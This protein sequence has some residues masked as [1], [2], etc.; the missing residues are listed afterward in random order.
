MG[1][2]RR[3]QGHIDTNIFI[4]VRE[5]DRVP[6]ALIELFDL[7]G[8]DRQFELATSEIA[9]PELIAKPLAESRHDLVEAYD[10]WMVASTWLDVAPVTRSVL[11]DAGILRSRYPAVKLPD[12]IHLSTAVATACSLFLTADTGIKGRYEFPPSRHSRASGGRKVEIIRPEDGALQALLA[13]DER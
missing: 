11:W 10:D 9:L 12:A 13:G 8:K 1:R 4:A 3:A 6:P 2:L 5:A 7:A